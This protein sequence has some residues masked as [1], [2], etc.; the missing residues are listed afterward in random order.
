MNDIINDGGPAFPFVTLRSFA[1]GMS[2]RNWYAGM[3]LQGICAA[4]WNA[5][6]NPEETVR[7]SFR[8]ADAMIAESNKNER[9][10]TSA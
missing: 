4:S 1:P 8:M 5:M 10:T 7:A 2:L 3:A 9:P 6:N